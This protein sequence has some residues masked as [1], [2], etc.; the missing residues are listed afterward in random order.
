MANSIKKYLLIGELNA[1]ELEHCLSQFLF[2]MIAKII[3]KEPTYNKNLSSPNC[4]DLP[5]CQ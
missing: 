5:I 4:I 3:V 2:E 1:E